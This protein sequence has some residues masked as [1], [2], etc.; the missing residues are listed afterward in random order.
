LCLS[1]ACNITENKNKLA[2]KLHIAFDGALNKDL[3]KKFAGAR[4]TGNF[5]L[6]RS[7][8]KNPRHALSSEMHEFPCK[9]T[10]SPYHFCRGTNCIG[11]SNKG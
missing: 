11:S 1:C 7:Q 10:Y 6:K 3:V 9:D 4:L 5:S 2:N 8:W